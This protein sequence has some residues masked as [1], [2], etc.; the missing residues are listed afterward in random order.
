MITIGSHAS[1][2]TDLSFCND[3]KLFITLSNDNYI[4]VW[5]IKNI[6]NPILI[7]QSNSICK[8][9]L[10]HYFGKGV[11]HAICH[12]NSSVYTFKLNLSEISN[13]EQ[14]NLLPS[15]EIS[16]PEANL[17]NLRL[18]NNETNNIQSLFI[19]FGSVF[20]LQIKTLK[21]AKNY[22]EFKENKIILNSLNNQENNQIQISKSE[23][24]SKNAKI[25][26]EVEMTNTD[27][28]PSNLKDSEFKKVYDLITKTVNNH[29]N[30]G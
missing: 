16:I 9:A 17:I 30:L 5:H 3:N 22:L 14:K 15:N 2:V 24:V 26:N 19:L 4:N 1:N 11:Y 27:I 25:L 23:I 29:F 6:K 10:L 13:Q 7:L 21:Y 12:N 20:K 18:I 8:N 28:H